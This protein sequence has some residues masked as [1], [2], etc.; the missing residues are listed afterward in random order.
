[1]KNESFLPGLLFLFVSCPFTL[2]GSRRF[3]S[4]MLSL[5]YC[6]NVAGM[7]S[8]NFI[9]L[10][11]CATFRAYGRNIKFTTYDNINMLHCPFVEL[12]VKFKAVGP[13]IL[14][15]DNGRKV[16]KRHTNS[17]WKL[18]MIV[19]IYARWTLTSLPV[20]DFTS[21]WTLASYWAECT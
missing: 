10:W 5:C 4:I 16:E 14:W 6:I 17:T 19:T 9:N 13:Y 2:Y 15:N 11:I 7:W 20:S 12:K 8:K 18:R 21:C 1:V 3:F